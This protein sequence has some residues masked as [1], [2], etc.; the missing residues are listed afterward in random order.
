MRTSERGLELVKSFEGFY[1]R[2]V[3]FDN[4]RWVIGYGH[5]KAARA[6]LGI[7]RDEAEAVLREYDLPRVERRITELVMT[8]LNQ[9]Q[10]DALVSF[11]FNI[12]VREF[13]NSAVLAHLN[14]GEHLQAADAMGAWRVADVNGQT[15]L[16]DALVRRRAAETDLFLTPVGCR[17]TASR[18]KLA[19][20]FD[21]TRIPLGQIS[22][23]TVPE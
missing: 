20:K 3:S 13:R 17:V 23:S 8:P 22:V 21:E 5:T 15:V 18:A 16:I 2:A 19:P 14:A 11:V 7:L 10:F 6:G 4:G 12:G 1:R 9:H